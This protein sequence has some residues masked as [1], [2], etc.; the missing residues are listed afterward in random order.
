MANQNMQYI[1]GPKMDWTEDAGLHQR[2]KDWRE[3]VELLIDTVLSHI[4]NADTKMKFVTLWAGKEARTYLSTL[5]QDNRDSLKT[6]LDSLEEWTRP[7]S[8]EIAAFTHI[9]TLNQGNKTLS[10]Y[11]QEGCL[12]FG[13]EVVS[14][15]CLSVLRLLFAVKFLS[16]RVSSLDL[17]FT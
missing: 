7:K 5:E 12:K 2:F 8:D 3:E 1:Q 14:S 9:R 13:A 11:I 16:V 4:R 17:V 10:S 6:I 15:T